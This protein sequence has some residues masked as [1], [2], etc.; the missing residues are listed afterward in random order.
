MRDSSRDETAD[1]LKK[2]VFMYGASDGHHSVKTL[3]QSINAKQNLRT[4][5]YATFDKIEVTAG[6]LHVACID[7]TSPTQFNVPRW[8]AFAAAVERILSGSRVHGSNALPFEVFLPSGEDIQATSVD[9]PHQ[10][11]LNPD[12]CLSAKANGDAAEV[13][14]CMAAFTLA[15]AGL[16]LHSTIGPDV[17]KYLNTAGCMSLPYVSKTSGTFQLDAIFNRFEHAFDMS[18]VHRAPD[19]FDF[20]RDLKI[21]SLSH[22]SGSIEGAIDEWQTMQD[23]KGMTG[24]KLIGRAR[25]RIKHIGDDKKLCPEARSVMMSVLEETSFA[26]SPYMSTFF[27]KASPYVGSFSR[28]DQFLGEMTCLTPKGQLLMMEG[29]VARWRPRSLEDS[30]PITLKVCEHVRDSAALIDNFLTAFAK[31]SLVMPRDAFGRVRTRFLTVLQQD[32][33]M[34][35]GDLDL[36]VIKILESFQ[37]KPP[38]SSKTAIAQMWDIASVVWIW[39]A[40]LIKVNQDKL[41][42][43]RMVEVAEQ[44]ALERHKIVGNLSAAIEN[45]LDAMADARRQATVIFQSTDFPSLER[46]SEKYIQDGTDHAVG[47]LGKQISILVPEGTDAG[48]G[49]GRLSQNLLFSELA[50][51]RVELS[52]AGVHGDDSVGVLYLLDFASIDRE[53][54][55]KTISDTLLRD[56]QPTDLVFVILPEHASTKP[57]HLLHRTI[58]D[59]LFPD[60][61]I[62]IIKQLPMTWRKG[63]SEESQKC[64]MSCLVRLM[65]IPVVAEGISPAK[66]RRISFQPAS[67]R[68][69]M[70]ELWNLNA[71]TDLAS[72]LQGCRTSFTKNLPHESDRDDSEDDKELVGDK[73][74]SQDERPQNSDLEPR[75]LSELETRVDPYGT[76]LMRTLSSTQRSGQYGVDFAEDILRKA[77]HDKYGVR[78][79][80]RMIVVSPRLYVG[81]LSLAAFNSCVTPEHKFSPHGLSFCGTDAH[82]AYANHTLGR[83]RDHARKA[84]IKGLLIEGQPSYEELVIQAKVTYGSKKT[85]LDEIWDRCTRQL[86]VFRLSPASADLSCPRTFVHRTL[87][88]LCES[89]KVDPA[90]MADAFAAIPDGFFDMQAEESV[91]ADAPAEASMIHAVENPQSAAIDE[92]LVLLGGIAHDG[93]ELRSSGPQECVLR[94]LYVKSINSKVSSIKH[95]ILWRSSAATGRFTRTPPDGVPCVHFKLTDTSTVV[96]QHATGDLEVN[97]IQNLIEKGCIAEGTSAALRCCPAMIYAATLPPPR[98]STQRPYHPSSPSPPSPQNLHVATFSTTR[99]LHAATL[100]ARISTRPARPPQDQNSGTLPECAD[101]LDHKSTLHTLQRQ[102]CIR[103]VSQRRGGSASPFHAPQGILIS[104]YLGNPSQ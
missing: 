3:L 8:S 96:F 28:P 40:D 35:F 71:L 90:S 61:T 80:E 48:A 18:A 43:A 4:S 84:F 103:A 77:L 74:Q 50:R 64:T 36:V 29:L 19:D 16:E 37:V 95:S 41:E 62:F 38:C 88:E 15:V 27:D 55:A 99:D 45:D 89:S 72:P 13:C 98:I 75:A 66:R 65:A 39:L 68:W 32:D 97:T 85:H 26:T 25:S 53:L 102:S 67:S 60:P 12:G 76:V 30:K 23:R 63:D 59:M 104:I 78:I 2:Q 7:I 24:R 57:L 10:Q 21:Y 22:P 34:K 42:H 49:W 9:N 91:I 100:P 73:S 82:S 94:C 14:F 54:H 92:D 87:V 6:Y 58:M 83:F 11:L 17:E 5:L 79:W 69:G 70:T 101:V 81:D 20:A 56:L 52:H 46:E 51:I 47:T 33:S 31:H 44:A 1:L 86:S 93:L